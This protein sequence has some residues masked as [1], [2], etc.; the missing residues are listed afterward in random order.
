LATPKVE[1][2]VET[3]SMSAKFV[4]LGNR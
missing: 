3:L 4:L 2:Y 1:K